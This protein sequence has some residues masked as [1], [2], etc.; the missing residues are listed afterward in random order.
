MSARGSCISFDSYIKPQQNAD[1]F[2]HVT[3]V[4]LLIPTSNHNQVCA[5]E[6][7]H[8]VVY[9]LI[10]TLNH[11]NDTTISHAAKVVYLLIPTSNHN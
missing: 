8:L 3:V 11:N 1:N 2:F 10:P 6:V 4:Y 5:V 9:L 7:V